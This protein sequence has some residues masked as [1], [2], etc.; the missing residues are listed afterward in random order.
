MHL[1]RSLYIIYIHVSVYKYIYNVYIYIYIYL[2]IAHMN[3]HQPCG[4]LTYGECSIILKT[5]D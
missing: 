3:I 5:R 4:Q 2:Y 1:E